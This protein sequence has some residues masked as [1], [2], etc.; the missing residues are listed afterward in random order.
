L[1]RAALAGA[2]GVSVKDAPALLAHLAGPEARDSAEC[3]ICLQTLGK[4]PFV[5]DCGHKFHH[6]CIGRWLNSPM[7]LQRSRG[8]HC[9][10]PM[11]RAPMSAAKEAK[12]EAGELTAPRARVPGVVVYCALPRAAALLQ[13][14]R[15][16]MRRLWS[17]RH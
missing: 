4:K 14:A 15:S 13:D 7:G 9:S 5:L 1:G 10:C 6:A 12:L 3:S 17:R 11:C 16:S 2:P 8:A